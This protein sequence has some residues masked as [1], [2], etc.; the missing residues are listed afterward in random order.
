[1]TGIRESAAGT[2]PSG[3]GDALFQVLR[4]F[5]GRDNIRFTF[6][7]DQFNGITRDREGNVR[8]LK[9]RP[10]ASVSQAEEENGQSR[11]YLGIHWAFDKIAGIEQGRDVAKFVFRDAFQP[12]R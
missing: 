3:F 9:P 5:Y 11:M 1:M 4:L 2:G 6:V 10:F 7:S 8:P 12:Y